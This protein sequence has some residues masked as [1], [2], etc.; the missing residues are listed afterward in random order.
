LGKRVSRRRVKSGS[1]SWLLPHL[2]EGT[3]TL[4]ATIG[5]R[6][7]RRIVEVREGRPAVVA[8]SQGD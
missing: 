8:L 6:T 3:W 1:G 7:I 4:E 5:G 2:P